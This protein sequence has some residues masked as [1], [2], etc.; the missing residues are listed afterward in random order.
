MFEVHLSTK[1]KKE[2]EQLDENL[3]NRIV[4]ILEILQADP[5]PVR[6]Y[7]V[8]K[9]VGVENTYRIRIGKIRIIYTVIWKD[10]VVVVSKIGFRG[11]VY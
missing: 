2:L 6:F 7:D 10:K 8:K 11:R 5:V 9:M 1:A 3:R 4:K